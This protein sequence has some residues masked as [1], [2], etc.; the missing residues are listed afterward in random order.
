MP[1]GPYITSIKKF[2]GPEIDLAALEDEPDPVVQGQV[3]SQSCSETFMNEGIDLIILLPKNLGMI[4][5]GSNSLKAKEQ[6]MLER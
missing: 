6:D 2:H 5:I 3:L 4:C 1:I